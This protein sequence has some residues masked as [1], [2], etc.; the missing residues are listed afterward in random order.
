MNL[1]R[2]IFAGL[3][4]TLIFVIPVAI[5]AVCTYIHWELNETHSFDR[6]YDVQ[7][8][9]RRAFPGIF[10]IPLLLFFSGLTNFSLPNSRRLG[11]PLTLILIT[12][13]SLPIAGILGSLG[14]AHPRIKSI[15]H[16]PIYVSEIL[17]FLIPV[18]TLSFVVIWHRMR[19]MPK[20]AKQ[21][22]SKHNT[23]SAG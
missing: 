20:N 9:R 12:V 1:Q 13:C 23:E 7:W 11:M 14:M 6:E 5:I 18:A 19:T 15:Q 3:L 22:S 17:M 21:K 10:A 2:G 8:W 16:P 4:T